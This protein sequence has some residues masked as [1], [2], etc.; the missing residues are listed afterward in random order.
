MKHYVILGVVLIGL[1]VIFNEMKVYVA[2]LGGFEYIQYVSLILEKASCE[3]S[4]MH[5]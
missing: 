5:S 4:D 3:C 1:E 2:G